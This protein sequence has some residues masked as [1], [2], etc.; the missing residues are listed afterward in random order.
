[1][2]IRGKPNI[3]GSARAFGGLHGNTW[4]VPDPNSERLKFLPLAFFF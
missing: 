3:A 4:W 1:M 2:E